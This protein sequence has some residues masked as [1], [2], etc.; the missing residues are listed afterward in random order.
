MLLQAGPRFFRGKVSI[1]RR[2]ERNIMKILESFV[3]SRERKR[4]RKGDEF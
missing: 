1:G 4:E 2:G 3:F